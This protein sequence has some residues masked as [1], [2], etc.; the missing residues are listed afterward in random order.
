MALNKNNI[1]LFKVENQFTITGSG[2]ILT[3]GPGDNVKFI[4]T[5]AQV[6]LV[7]PDKSE[8]ITTIKGI[9]FEGTHDILISEEFSKEE[10]PVGT[11]VWTNE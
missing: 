10:V 3:P 11:E 6:R 7:K 1:L 2:L 8:L 5:G 9:T 4:T